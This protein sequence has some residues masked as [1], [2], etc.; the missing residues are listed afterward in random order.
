MIDLQKIKEAYDSKNFAILKN[1]IDL[2]K[3]NINFNFDSM[4]ELNAIREFEN[5]Q[6]SIMIGQILGL[7][8]E[9]LFCEYL[10]Y[11]HLNFKNIFNYNLGNLDFFYSLNG[12]KGI[13]HRD[14]EHVLILGVKNSTYYHINNQDVMVGE[15]DL[16]FI[17]KNLWHHSFSSRERIILSLSLFEIF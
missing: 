12:S 10:K 15:G 16:L 11:I 7:Q 5:S 8:K 3:F 13:P 4:F 17:Y 14:T 2:K 9:N 1:A 6:K